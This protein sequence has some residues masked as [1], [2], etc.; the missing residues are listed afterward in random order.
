M[1]M[2]TW[3]GRGF[4]A[5]LGLGLIGLALASAGCSGATSGREDPLD[6]SPEKA[7]K[8]TSG[9]TDADGEVVDPG[10]I[11]KGSLR[12]HPAGRAWVFEPGA[13]PREL[14]LG[15][16]EARGYTVIDLSNG[17]VP[18]IF[19][20]KTPGVDDH[21]ENAYAAR[22]VDLADDRTDDDGD[23]LADHQHNYLELYGIPP[24]LR[25]I[26]DEWSAVEREVQT[27]LDEA[28]YDPSVFS[29]L[30]GNIVFNREGRKRVKRARWA[31]GTLDGA[32]KKARIAGDYAAA[33]TH[34][35][36][37]GKYAAWRE[38][39]DEVDVIA[40]AQRRFRCE[41]LFN[42][43]K[44][45]GKFVEGD[46]DN[47]THHALAAFEKKHNIMGWGH[48]TP[49][50]MDALGQSAV[51]STHA[52]LLRVVRERVVSAAGILEDGSASKRK[53][54]VWT[55]A[56]GIEHEPRD[57][58]GEFS[59][60]TYAALGI[61][62]PDEARETLDKL[63]ALGDGDFEQLLVAVKLP[64]K[65]AYYS[66]HMALDAVIDRG[67][68]WYDYPFDDEGKRIPQ[69]RKRMPHLTLYVEYEGQRIPLVHW[70]TTIGSW[71][72]EEEDGQEWYA[73]KNSD[74][75]ERVWKDIMAGPTWI[76]PKST[77]VKSLLK[78]KYKDNKLQTV[79]NYDET[80]PGY[81]SAY[82]LVAAYHIKQVERKDGTVA[83]LDNQIRTHGSVDYMS[84]LRRF[85]H[86]CHRL[87]NMNAV[88]VFSFV[89]QHR[90]YVRH[91]QREIG[92]A[93]AFEYEGRE[94]RMRLGTRGY[95]FELTPPIHVEVTEGRIRGRRKR[96]IE[97]MMPKP[98]VDY[99]EEDAEDADAD[100]TEA[101]TPTIVV[102]MPGQDGA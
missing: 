100:A 32:M 83:E 39:Q 12:E 19:S 102:P 91:G 49:Q 60:A 18:Y 5:S 89:L 20:S 46:F 2:A 40:N 23:P 78:R 68:I 75:G 47:A 42:G 57:L 50:N 80:G 33:A 9:Q 70:R 98:G 90:D 45:A 36:T 71:R 86:G 95:N 44:G 51:E 67:D 25:V 74:V 99:S 8:G 3:I 72:T 41:K 10:P 56:D 52:R 38:L 35:K 14:D 17:W 76:P 53:G 97:E 16:A 26:R 73:Y 87:Y 11:T 21:A 94:H 85:S 13:P 43:N 30:S 62:S 7:Q 92:F 1:T 27:C 65:P 96:P 69:P 29:K 28:G 37:K 54:A 31:K 93:R 64:Q 82:G 61:E 4:R 81:K 55:D 79:V 77:P 22:Y 66:S 24:T 63:A 101:G 34:P 6:P 15:S 59:D 88:R 58:V 48:F 84:I